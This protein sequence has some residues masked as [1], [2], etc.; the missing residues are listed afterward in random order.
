MRMTPAHDPDPRA[1]LHPFAHPTLGVTLQRF[2]E[3]HR[4]PIELTLPRRRVQTLR[5]LSPQRQTVCIHAAVADLRLE[6]H[7]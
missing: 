3:T 7:P 1:I 5:A 4:I 2:R 6:G